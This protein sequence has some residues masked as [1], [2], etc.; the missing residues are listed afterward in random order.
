MG[1]VELGA[2]AGRGAEKTGVDRF[3]SLQCHAGEA[4][5]EGSSQE[6]GGE[7]LKGLRGYQG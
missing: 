5:T 4:A 1:Q 3:W 7:G 2:E 6:G